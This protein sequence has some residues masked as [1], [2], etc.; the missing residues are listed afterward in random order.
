MSALHDAVEAGNTEKVKHLLDSGASV[1]QKDKEG[2]TALMLA[3]SRSDGPAERF[4]RRRELLVLLV[5]K[6]ASNNP[7]LLLASLKGETEVVKQLLD[8]KAPVD[9]KDENGYTALMWASLAGN[10]D[11][12]KLLLDKGA[13]FDE[14]DEDGW[15]ALMGASMMGHTE[16]VK[17]LHDKGAP[18]DDKGKDGSNALILASGS[19]HK[20]VMKFLLDK[21]SPV[22]EIDE[23]GMTALMVAS[24]WGH[25]EAVK[26]LLD[27]G[28][29]VDQKNAFNSTALLLARSS[30]QSYWGRMEVVKLLLDKGASIGNKDTDG[31][32]ALPAVVAFDEN[33]LGCMAAAQVHRQ[34]LQG[35]VDDLPTASTATAVLQLVKLAGFARDRAHKLRSSDP[36]LADECL[37]LF[38]RLQLAAAACAQSDESGEAPRE[39]R[40]VQEL[41]CSDNGSKALEHAVQIKAK[42]L[43]S[44]PVVQKFIKFAWA[45]K[46]PVEISGDHLAGIVPMFDDMPAMEAAWRGMFANG[47]AFQWNALQ[48]SMLFMLLLLQLFFILPLVAL[49]PPLEPWLIKTLDVYANLY[50]L[51]LPVVKFGLECAADLALALAFTLIPAANLAT[52][53]VAPLLLVWVG[54]ELLWE[55]RQLMASSSGTKSWLARIY[56]C[57]ITYWDDHINRVDATALILSFA[58]LIAFLTAD[59][60]EDAS[61]TSLRAAAVLVLW[62]RV[63]RVLLISPLFGPFVLM[64]WRMLFGDVLCFLVLLSFVLVAFAASWTVLLEHLETAGCADELGGADVDSTRGVVLVWL[65]E[66]ALTGKDFLECA[67]DSTD[68]PV[69]AWMISFVYVTLTAVLLLNMLIAMCAA[70][71]HTQL[72]TLFFG[73]TSTLF[74]FALAGW[75]RPLTTSRR[76]R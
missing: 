55:A 67:R 70:A 10:T 49:V 58:A 40:R 24:Y 61:A 11:A 35:Q 36:G 21:N 12:V 60:S 1:D 45:G 22:D 69:A 19:G 27:K 8:R 75:P 33:Q 73:L 42:E 15:T 2:R 54:S 46:L 41:F 43:L 34:L 71:T 50:F 72:A 56:D 3:K 44:Q 16:V 74:S 38:T 68:S 20:D 18:V 51:R 9:E 25:T 5:E 13:A 48:W 37:V 64:F 39:E 52:A 23:H 14:K 28:A 47:S 63:V 6:R 66:G 59:D 26:L 53:P 32:T 29:S 7:A 76:R 17:L 65:L 30:P 57:I 62:F 31:W 4:G